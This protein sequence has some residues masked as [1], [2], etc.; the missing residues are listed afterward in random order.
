M[1]NLLK[2][3]SC[4]TFQQICS[5]KEKIRIFCLRTFQKSSLFLYKSFIFLP[6]HRTAL[7]WVTNEF[8]Y[9]TLTHIF[10][11]SLKVIKSLNVFFYYIQIII[12][13]TIYCWGWTSVTNW[14]YTDARSRSSVKHVTQ[15]LL[16][17]RVL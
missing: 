4:Y 5:K 7:T 13:T 10:K 6:L 3:W 9:N 15:L 2:S 16:K 1:I 11:S 17:F 8:L 14:Q 12:C